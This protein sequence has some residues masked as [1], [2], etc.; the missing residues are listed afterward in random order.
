MLILSLSPLRRDPRVLKQINLFRGR[1]RVITCGYGPAPDGVAEHVEIDPACIGWPRDPKRLALRRYR[2]VYWNVAGVAEA[3]RLLRSRRFGAVLANDLNTV[4]LALSLDS[5]HGVHADLHEFGPKE[6]F[7]KPAWRAL[8]APYMRWLCRTSLP[9]AASVTTVSA[10]IARQYGLDFGVQAAVVTNAAPYVRKQPRPTGSTIRLIHSTAGQRYRRIEDIIEAF[11]GIRSGIELDLIVMPNEP[12]YVD[13]LR[14]LAGQVP[15]VRFRD[16]VPYEQLVDTVAEYDVAIAYLP[17]TNFNLAQALPNKFF[18]AVQARTGLIIGPS[19]AMVELVR[20]HGLGAVARDF[21]TAG[22]REVLD[23][24][25]PELVDGW[26][27]HADQAA[28][29]L[30]A[31][32]QS[33]GWET[34]VAA[35]LDPAAD[36][37]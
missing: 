4:P 3:Y 8:V 21:S 35:L 26:K 15:A 32:Y 30:S 37:A 14:R 6:H 29:V 28:E 27:Q 9:R 25:T 18:E 24:L 20:R 2:D 12:G 11:R 1:Y 10:G 19:P 22:L 34:A 13:E 31:E 17:P 7:D 5:T 23:S 33:R 16:P 36:R